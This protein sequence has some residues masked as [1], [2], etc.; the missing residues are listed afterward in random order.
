M[1]VSRVCLTTGVAPFLVDS[2]LCEDG[3]EDE[4][5]VDEDEADEDIFYP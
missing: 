4:D 2:M 1:C 5:E 3:D